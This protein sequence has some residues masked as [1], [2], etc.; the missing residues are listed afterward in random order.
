MAT[1][2]SEFLQNI[3]VRCTEQLLNNKVPL[4]YSLA[5]EA[6]E[7][8]LNSDQLQRCVEA[9]NT[10]AYL[11]VLSLSED[12][13]AEFPIAKYAEVMSIIAVPAATPGVEKT[14]GVVEPVVTEGSLEKVASSGSALDYSTPEFSSHEQMLF[15]IK[16]A[17]ANEAALDRA[18]NKSEAIRLELMK[19]AREVEADPKG[20]DKMAC[21]LDSTF[22]P[23]SVLVTG[24]VQT[25][26]DFGNA[27]PYMFKEAELKTV[28]KLYS[29]YKQAQDLVREVSQRRDLSD[30]ASHVKQAHFEGMAKEAGVISKIVGSKVTGAVVRGATNFTKAPLTNSV[31]GLAN[32]ASYPAALPIRAARGIATGATRP[33]TNA[34]GA[35]VNKAGNTATIAAAKVYNKVATPLGAN[36]VTPKVTSFVPK[37]SI[38]GSAIAASALPLTWAAMDAKM[39]GHP[40][41]DKSTGAPRDVWEGL[42]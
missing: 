17:A 39:V 6:S 28:G 7:N 18:I 26:R 11:K 30:R 4:N 21:S 1:I 31:H 8:G 5:K 38:V 23:L 24:Q 3:A 13:T 22:G 19:V 35:A 12:R 14:A 36:P 41:Y 25:R 20:L 33:I 42:R 9:A 27:A 29:L 37:K 15:L 34:V 40:G 2:D 32:V 16:E 10:V